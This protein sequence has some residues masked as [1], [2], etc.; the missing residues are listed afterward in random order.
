MKLILNAVAKTDPGKV[1]QNNEDSVFAYTRP[2]GQGE[3]LGLLIVADGIGGHKAGEVASKMAIDTI[4]DQL[5]DLILE[6][7]NTQKK[8]LRKLTLKSIED[9]LRLA[10]E[11]ANRVIYNFSKQNPDSAGGLGSTI[12]CSIIFGDTA[13]VA[14]VGDSRSYLFRN[15]ILKQISEDHSYVSALIRKGIEPHEAY[16]HHPYRNVITRSLGNEDF[17]E[18]DTWTIGL[19]PGD[20][21]LLCSDGLWEVIASD[22]LIENFLDNNIKIEDSVASLI[23]AA[24]QNGGKDNIGIV[25][26][27]I[28]AAE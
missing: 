26:A 11:S 15:G 1:Y 28:L 27:E 7:T 17:V 9:K 3:P 14:N 21:L 13:I 6:E 2:T 20:R 19:E 12:A 23:K 4:R 10:V 25:I 24:N 22:E 8:I 16:Y 18:V 5:K